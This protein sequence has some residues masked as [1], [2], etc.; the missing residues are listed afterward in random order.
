[1]EVPQGQVLGLQTPHMHW[2]IIHRICH[3]PCKNRDKVISIAE[4]TGALLYLLN[5][6][7]TS[8]KADCKF[9]AMGKS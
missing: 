2:L 9:S 1:M 6:T 7:A 4:I 8:T 5:Q 3:L